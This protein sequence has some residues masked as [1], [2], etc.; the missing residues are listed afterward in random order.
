M[1]SWD[2]RMPEFVVSVFAEGWKETTLAARGASPDTLAQ[3]LG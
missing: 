1:L 3:E 2:A